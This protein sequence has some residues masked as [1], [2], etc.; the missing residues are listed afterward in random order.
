MN[1]EFLQSMKKKELISFIHSE[2]QESSNFYNKTSRK[3]LVDLYILKQK[4]AGQFEAIEETPTAEKSF[5]LR[6]L[7]PKIM[8]SGDL[9]TIAS[10]FIQPVPSNVNLPVRIRRKRTKLNNIILQ[11]VANE[12]ESEE[13]DEDIPNVI[14]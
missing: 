13:S 12:L 5:L 2:I 3:E 9:D 1:I 4:Q 6:P 10:N 7:L 11:N 14:I 8:H